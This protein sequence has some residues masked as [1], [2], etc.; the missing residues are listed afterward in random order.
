MNTEST[1]KDP[2]SYIYTSS[3]FGTESVTVPKLTDT[4]TWK[5]TETK[6]PTEDTPGEYTYESSYGTIT[7]PVPALG[8]DTV[9]TKDTKS[10]KAPT[11]DEDGKDVYK[12]DYGTVEVVLPATGAVRK[13]VK[14]GENAPEATLATPNSELADMLLTDAEKTDVE[15]GTNITILL[16][17]EDATTTVSTEDTEAVEA[18]LDKMTL[19]QYL[20]VGLFK[21]T[22]DETGA[23]TATDTISTTK[24]PIRITFEIP[25]NL[26]GSNRTFSVIRVHGGETTVLKDLDSNDNTV[27]IETDKFS[28]YALAYVE[29]KGSSSSNKGGGSGSASSDTSNNHLPSDTGASGKGGNPATGI[30][31]PIIPT[32]AAVTILMASAKRRRK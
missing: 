13:E 21:I 3:D 6:Q 8:D 27:T 28:T 11:E 14:S 7:Q 22:S 5:K 15:N 30:V 18:A 16:T 24:K 25:D 12:S 32:A 26:R 9:W 31:L 20:D 10:S 2:G 4:N 23:T 1:V 19:G 17:V 29:R